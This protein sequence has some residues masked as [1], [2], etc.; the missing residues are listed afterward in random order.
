MTGEAGEEPARRLGLGAEQRAMPRARVDNDLGASYSSVTDQ[1]IF[2]PIIGQID[3][4]GLV[5]I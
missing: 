3:S 5:N 1:Q 2:Q 4:P